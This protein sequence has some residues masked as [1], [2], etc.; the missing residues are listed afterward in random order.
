MR[1]HT[2]L[3]TVAVSLCFATPVEWTMESGGNGHSYD[4]VSVPS[5][6][7]WTQAKV[8]AEDRGGYLATITS[9]AE[10]DFVFTLVD[11]ATHFSSGYGWN[12]T[13]GPWLGG[14]QDF[15]SSTPS[16]NWHWVTGEAWDYTNWDS[17]HPGDMQDGEN[18][19]ENYLH[20]GCGYQGDW[21]KWNDLGNRGAYDGFREP[22][23][24]IISYVVEYEPIPEPA[25]LM[26]LGMGALLIRKR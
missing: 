26:L 20:Y 8:A 17:N 14:Y 9:Q 1:T 22:P 25:T 10:S 3:F 6:I 23:V 5:G 19:D 2:F 13:W 15:G 12:L 24:A 4:V 16:E 21:S 7:W 11:R 18:G